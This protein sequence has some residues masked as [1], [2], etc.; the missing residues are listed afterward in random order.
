M[1]QKSVSTAQSSCKGTRKTYDDEFKVKVVLEA[2]REKVP[3]SEL[4]SKY[5]VYPNQ[6]S[7]RKAKFPAN[8]HV[9]PRGESHEKNVDTE[10]NSI[11][12]LNI[13]GGHLKYRT[14]T[15]KKTTASGY[16][17]ENSVEFSIK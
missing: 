13:T 11:L 14:E 7:R 3:L 8:A 16:N 4:A 10:Q 6:I 15:A 9:T 5:E 12:F 1:P 17:L 2:L